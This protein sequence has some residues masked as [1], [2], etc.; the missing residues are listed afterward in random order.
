MVFARRCRGA[1]DAFDVFFQLFARDGDVA[2]AFL[3]NDPD[4]RSDAKDAEIGVAAGVRFFHA[5]DIVYRQWN[6]ARHKPPA[7]VIESD[8]Y[9]IPYFTRFF[10]RFQKS[11]QSPP[12]EKNSADGGIRSCIWRT[13]AI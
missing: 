6:D 13:V 2:P 11:Y 1:L 9:T 8:A 3:A 12:Q 7:F 10:N 5:D 4:I